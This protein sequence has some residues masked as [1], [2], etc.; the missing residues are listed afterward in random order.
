[1][2]LC[3]CVQRE[4]VCEEKKKKRESNWL[5]SYIQGVAF[6]QKYLLFIVNSNLSPDAVVFAQ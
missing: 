3:Y 4:D 6:V 5:I 1:M 2:C